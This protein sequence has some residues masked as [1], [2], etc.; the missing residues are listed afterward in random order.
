MPRH[1]IENGKKVFFTAE[2]E[3]EWDAKEIVWQAGQ[4]DRDWIEVRKT[5]DQL[6]L[7]SDFTQLD[8]SPKDKVVWKN[9][10]QVLRD[11]TDQPDPGNITW[12]TP[13]E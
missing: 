5:R 13:P 6:L 8:D 2:R 7:K 10:R 3:A 1:T 12:P 11:I 9:Y 4:D